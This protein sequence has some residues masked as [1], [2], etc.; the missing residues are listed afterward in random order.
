MPGRSLCTGVRLAIRE[1]VLGLDHPD[2]A[3][4]LNNLGLLLQA[5][6]DYTSAEPPYRRAL[7][8]VQKA[9]GPDHPDVADL[10]NLGSA[11]CLVRSLALGL[12]SLRFLKHRPLRQSFHESCH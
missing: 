9:L 11:L 7:A 1:K 10:N 2:V 12:V 8:I 5:K 6:G 4:S 3:M